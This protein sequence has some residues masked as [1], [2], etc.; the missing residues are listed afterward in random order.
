MKNNNETIPAETI[1]QAILFIHGQKIILDYD[2]AKLYG[3]TTKRLNEQ[4]KRN[5]NRFPKDFMFRLNKQEA[6]NLR[7]QSATSKSRGGRRY[8]PFAFTEHGVVMSAN[9]LNSATAIKISIDIV[10]TFVRLRQ[11]ITAHKNLA[12]RLNQLENKYDAQFK[13]V[14]D[15]IRE[16]MAP[17][18]KPKKRIG[19]SAK[20]KRAR[21]LAKKDLKK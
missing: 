13:I 14:F 9:V 5:R 20:E 8:L 1:E 17:P 12:K 11:M 4:V 10:R 6:K 19:F 21:Y 7:S 2:L 15:A 18:A 16:L 3:V